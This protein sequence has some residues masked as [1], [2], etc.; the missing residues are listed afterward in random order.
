MFSNES[1]QSFT[2]YG[3]NLWNYY[4]DVI[5][6]N[7]LVFEYYSYKRDNTL[8]SPRFKI[9]ISGRTMNSRS[10][11]S[12]GVCELHRFIYQLNSNIMKKLKEFTVA[13]K[14]DQKFTEGFSFYTYR[15]NIYVTFMWNEL[16]NQPVI[17][18]MLGEKEQTILDSD[19]V[20]VPLVD[21]ISFF[22]MIKQAHSTYM[23]LCMNSNI[24]N[25]LN[26]IVTMLNSTK[27]LTK[28]DLSKIQPIIQNV[29]VNNS[30]STSD[31]LDDLKDISVSSNAVVRKDEIVETPIESIAESK[32]QNDFD[33]FLS[34]NRDK[35]D[36]DL[37]EEDTVTEKVEE[38]KG[39]SNELNSIE[40]LT[41]KFIDKVCH[42]DLSVFETIITN[43]VN[44][45]LPLDSLIKVIKE[46][47]EIDFRNGISD[48][49]YNAINYVV[50]RMVKTSIK[51][52][53]E[54]RKQ[55]PKSTRPILV[56]SSDRNE[57]KIDTMYYMFTMYLYLSKVR[58]VL[59]EKSK[60]AIDNKEFFSFVLK[61]ITNPLVF[62]YFP[63]IPLDVIKTQVSKRYRK[64]K[65]S[66]FFNKFND[67]I[68]VKLKVKTIDIFENDLIS[69]VEKVYNGV[70][71]HKDKIGIE[72]AFN[73]GIMKLTYND[74]KT[75]NFSIESV[76][77]LIHFDSNIFR[78][79]K[80]DT[81]KL[82][83]KSYDDVPTSI[84]KKYG[85]KSL[86]FD[87]TII[88][89]YFSDNF[90]DFQD[91][92]KIKKINKN[93]Y[94][95]LDEIDLRSYNDQQLRALYFWDTEELP[96]DLTY[97]GFKKMIDQSSLTKNE[98]VSMIVDRQKTIDP[99][100]YNSFLVSAED[101]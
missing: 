51:D 48:A 88:T 83:L 81:S 64:L 70:V 54:N 43:S 19:K 23:M 55:L 56:N 90:K 13:V 99:E 25:R 89:K 78:Y 66:G 22:E 97:S 72:T 53:I 52:L 69:D 4:D 31:L 39:V 11:V 59:A 61:S 84:L 10:S 62:S 9:T 38:K 87:N 47:T 58:T 12:L 41:S 100:F 7:N 49:D 71:T 1:E 67:A 101:D 44:E 63:D 5:S 16:S 45:I 37:P 65:D 79:G 32:E 26:E 28:D 96:K 40:N 77:K 86:K 46:A 33:S 20:Y 6:T 93:V 36:L 75:S 15:K 50:S 27:F 35:F 92:D 73:S 34:Q 8:A 17:R 3:M 68:S 91:F 95:I 94:D 42:N 14:S 85:I 82:D 74:F 29:S 2:F 76:I 98:L 30:T 60:N 18:F 57:D 21:M 80:I 24:E